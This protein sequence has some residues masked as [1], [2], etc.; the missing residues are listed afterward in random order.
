MAH[1]PTPAASPTVSDW[2][3][4][5]ARGPVRA[6][7]DIP[8]SKSITNRALLLAAIAEGPGTLRGALA[9][10][11]TDDMVNALRGLGIEVRVAEHHWTVIP[12]PLTGPATV[13]CGQAGTVARFFPPVASLARGTVVL[14]GSEQLRR[15]PLSTVLDALRSLGAP[16]AG[17]ALPLRIDGVGAVRGG[18]VELDA[19]G[20]SQFVSGLLL[21]AARFD[22]GVRITHVGRSLPSAPHIAMTVQMLRDRGVAVTDELPGR[23]SVAPGPVGAVD[24]DVEPDLSNAAPFLAAALVTGGEVTI[25]KW[26]DAG[27][28]PGGRLLEVLASM[29][30]SWRFGSEGL[31]FTGS[32]AV[33]G[34]DV[35]LSDLSELPPVLSVVA[36]LADSPTRLRG[37]AHLRNHET[38]RLHALATE[39]GALGAGVE[40]T[41][42]GLVITPRP[43][44]G[45]T[46]DTYDDHRLATA[47]AVLGLATDGI[48]V[49]NVATTAKTMPGFVELW[50]RM[51]EPTP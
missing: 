39:L 16:I 34:I 36:A 50:N 38:D 7:V 45:G 33:H 31:T 9:A 21:A 20:S 25:P 51:L 37:I 30:G 49:R 41:Q 22:R 18:N 1:S 44:H 12:G 46:F 28:Q 48:V 32:G 24:V 3:A 14:D 47:A 19:S 17:D 8:G 10:R 13:D 5:R 4:P 26:F 43:L 6:R 15:R 23:W 42:D 27:L 35:D 2:P 11:D 29:G 40:E